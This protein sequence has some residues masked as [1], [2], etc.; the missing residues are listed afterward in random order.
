MR[1]GGLVWKTAG[2]AGENSQNYALLQKERSCT[3]LKNLSRRIGMEF[4]KITHW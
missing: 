3:L 2:L 4:L 1:G